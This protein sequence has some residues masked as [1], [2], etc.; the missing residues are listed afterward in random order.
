[1]PSGIR[2]VHKKM[3]HTKIVHCGFM[4]DIGTRDETSANAGIAH[5][6]EHMAFKGTHKRKAYHIINRLEILGG[7]LNAYTTKDK[8]CIYSS[9][10]Q[11]HF[12][13]AFELLVDITFNSIFPEKEIEKERGVILEEM[14]MYID[15]P[16]DAICDEFENIVFASHPLGK[17]ILGNQKTIKSITRADF[18][19]FIEKHLD[20]NK[21][22]FSS[23][24]NIN[25]DTVRLVA[26]KYLSPIPSKT[27]S[28]KRKSFTKYKAQKI[29]LIKQYSQSHSV[30]GRDAYNIFHKERLS[31]FMLSNILGGPGMNSRLNLAL[32]ERRGL[33]YTVEATYNSYV[34]TGLLSIY[35]GTEK[36][37]LEKAQEII[38]AELNKLKD[39]P[40]GTLQLS[41]YKSQLIGQLA[42]AEESNVSLMQMMAKSML[43]MGAIEA[44]EDIF[45]KISLITSNQ[46]Q[47][48][49]QEIFQEQEL[50]ILTYKSE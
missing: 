9:V 24:G 26:E 27:S 50:S 14:S 3:Q 39:T 16:E 12:E 42:M 46:L 36:K 8:I 34:D 1:M 40:L 7:E 31:L 11:E 25:S 10:I 28:Y 33:V 23:V 48:V 19:N 13:T 30:I 17:N 29:E 43:D 32:R 15:L 38:A 44:L 37:N 22:V 4:L 2:I 5:F 41:A 21:V 35:F 49:A 45:Y 6:W 20:T 18:I 47:S